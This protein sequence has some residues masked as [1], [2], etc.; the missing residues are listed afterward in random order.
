MASSR[1]CNS[2]YSVVSTRSAEDFSIATG[3]H[4]LML[5][6]T[7]LDIQFAVQSKDLVTLNRLRT[8]VI[9]HS[10]NPIPPIRDQ[11]SNDSMPT[12]VTSASHS[13]SSTRDVAGIPSG[14]PR[15]Y[16]SGGHS[17]APQQNSMLARTKTEMRLAYISLATFRFKES[18]FYEFVEQVLGTIILSG[19]VSVSN[20]QKSNAKYTWPNS[21]SQQ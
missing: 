16:N 7:K 10:G 14:Y 15:V 6:F 20:Y 19:K 12:G 2:G 13:S 1:Y 3:P 21:P 18:P 5:T 11:P 4:M 9:G 8:R 17:R